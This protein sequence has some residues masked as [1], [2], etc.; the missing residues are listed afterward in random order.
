MSYT[1]LAALL[2]TIF[3]YAIAGL[4]KHPIPEFVTVITSIPLYFI[5]MYLMKR[6]KLFVLN[7]TTAAP[8]IIDAM[9]D[10]FLLVD[11]DGAIVNLN[12]A[13]LELLGYKEN[14]LQ[15]RAVKNI[16]LD[17]NAKNEL[18]TQTIR[19]KLEASFETRFLT[20]QG[21][22]VPASIATSVLKDN[23]GEAAGVVIIARDISRLKQS[24]ETLL[25]QSKALARSNQELHEFTYIVSHD[26]QEPLRK[27]IA[28]GDRLKAACRNSITEQ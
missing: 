12:Q 7:P 4:L 21:R 26:L 8:N 25:N 17:E 10:A 5:L 11:P 15:G 27:I 24:E 23:R 22:T 14:E 3:I 28:F 9:T 16:L 20:K 2:L 1:F 18:M 13:A 19:G 6:Y